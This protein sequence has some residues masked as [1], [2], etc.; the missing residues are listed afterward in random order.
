MRKKNKS[1]KVFNE[2]NRYLKKILKEVR[3][4]KNI[5]K[6]S[7]KDILKELLTKIK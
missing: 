1:N 7:L 4:R 5:E 2:P 6:A 3:K